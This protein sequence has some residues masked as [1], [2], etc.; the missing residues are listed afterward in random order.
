MHSKCGQYMAE[1]RALGDAGSEDWFPWKEGNGPANELS[2]P[3]PILGLLET[4]VQ[5]HLPFQSKDT[6]SCLH[7]TDQGSRKNTMKVASN[8]EPPDLPALDQQ[9]RTDINVESLAKMK[10]QPLSISALSDLPSVSHRTVSGHGQFNH[11][12][13]H[14]WK[15]NI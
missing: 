11:G 10:W 14:L 1:K 3:Q 8:T 6:C 15:R 4:Q 13:H 12:Q 2:T 9:E 5:R 7:K